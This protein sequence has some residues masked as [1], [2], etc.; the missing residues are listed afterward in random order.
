MLRGFRMYFD[1]PG[2]SATV[3]D[4]GQLSF[5]LAVFG[6]SNIIEPRS[7]TL[8]NRDQSE[9]SHSLESCLDRQP[10]QR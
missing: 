2:A 6:Y 9:A 1:V 3:V 5:S 4:H 7:R 8:E 10:Y